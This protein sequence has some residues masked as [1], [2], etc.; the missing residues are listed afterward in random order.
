MSH[1]L[2][3]RRTTEKKLAD[4]ENAVKGH[5]VLWPMFFAQKYD[6]N[7]EMGKAQMAQILVNPMFYV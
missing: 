2:A 4:F 3:R 7:K 6:F 1:F 5:G